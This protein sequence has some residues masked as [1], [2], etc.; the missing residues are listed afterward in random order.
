MKDW[1][2]ALIALKLPPLV[3]YQLRHGGA[4]ADLL[5]KRR[6][7]GEIM[8]RGRWEHPK[9][10]KRYAKSGQIQKTLVALN[11]KTREFCKWALDHLQGIVEANVA[12]R[13]PKW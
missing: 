10:M 8:Q 1:K 2:D 5:E 3:W 6:S 13:L 11:P 12:V 4:S 7:M 9:S